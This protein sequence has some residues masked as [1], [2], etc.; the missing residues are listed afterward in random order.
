MAENITS[1]YDLYNRPNDAGKAT[2]IQSDDLV[3]LQ[4]GTGSNRDKVIKGSDILASTGLVIATS[5]DTSPAPLLQKL[6]NSDTIAFE[7]VTV[8]GNKKVTADVKNA[9][10]DTAHLKDSAVTAA[11]L[12]S[13][14][15]TTAKIAE[16]AVTESKIALNSIQTA[17]IKDSAVTT[18]K[19]GD[20]SVSTAKLQNNAVTGAKL[21]SSVISYNVKA[22]LEYGTDID[23]SGNINYLAKTFSS[24]APGGLIDVSLFLEAV[25]P[26]YMSQ[27][28]IGIRKSGENTDEMTWIIGTMD[29]DYVMSHRLVVKNSTQNAV[30]YELRLFGKTTG[31]V[32][33]GLSRFLA[34]YI[35]LVGVS[36]A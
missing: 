32:P 28:S 10:I 21:D 14:S 18:A 19:L 36:I 27:V 24:V 3:Y 5:G 17:A 26:T 13:S 31:S 6:Y 11:K 16:G 23:G 30:N 20:G 8:S 7:D 33:S 9:S 2:D 4:R 22:E 29:P 12:G 25:Q 35:D 1:L 34:C 15:V